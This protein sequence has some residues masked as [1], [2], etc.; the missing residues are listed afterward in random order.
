MFVPAVALAIS[1]TN[2]TL[3]WTLKIPR[4]LNE[5]TDIV[6]LRTYLLLCIYL[7]VTHGLA[8]DEVH[9]SLA[10]DA[11]VDAPPETPLAGHHR[12]S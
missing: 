2:P 6:C 7:L 12:P 11:L 4:P 3:W 1:K 9:V 8:L 5:T 10:V